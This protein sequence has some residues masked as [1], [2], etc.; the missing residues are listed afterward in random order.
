MIVLLTVPGSK[1]L[2]Q[3]QAFLDAEIPLGMDKTGPS[4]PKARK[5]DSK[6]SL[7]DDTQ[8]APE[9]FMR[10]AKVFFKDQPDSL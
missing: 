5:L 4:P 7:P 6:K 8:F 3:H 2:Q 10:M 9:D 1:Q